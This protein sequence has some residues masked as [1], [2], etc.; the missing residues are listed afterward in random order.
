MTAVSPERRAVLFFPVAEP[1][2]QRRGGTK[3]ASGPAF[4]GVIESF[5]AEQKL[6]EI[7]V[8]GD[9]DGDFSVG[10]IAATGESS[11]IYAVY[12]RDGTFADFRWLEYS[13]VE[14]LRIDTVYLRQYERSAHPD[15]PPSMGDCSLLALLT[16][17]SESH[18]VCS[19]HDLE[20][21]EVLGIVRK[22][23]GDIVFV[24]EIVDGAPNGEVLLT[25]DNI[26]EVR[27]GGSVHSHLG[28]LVR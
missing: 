26:G 4:K 6:L 1:K 19:I 3:V 2:A 17:L 16:H 18:E 7:Y 13:N 10:H 8:R 23:E 24:W 27:F 14:Q 25:A 12:R 5:R 21:S 15:L 20:G 11:F 9:D 22:I 28:N